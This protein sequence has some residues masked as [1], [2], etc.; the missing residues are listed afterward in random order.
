MAE[1]M[2]V[3]VFLGSSSGRQER[4]ARDAGA[5]GTWLAR[6]GY[7]LVYGGSDSGTMG[8]LAKAALAAGGEV[9]GIMPRVLVERGKKFAGLGQFILTDNMDD[10]KH[11]LMQKGDVIVGLPGGAGTLEEISE[12]MA[13]RL[14]GLICCPVLI[15]SPDGFYEPL[16]QQYAAMA[17]QG[18]VREEAMAPITFCPTLEAVEEKI[19][20]RAQEL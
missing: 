3:T 1:K 8:V 19:T 6:Q 13:N 20:A 11:L 10:R 5:L 9:T 4:Y 17:A 7:H 18:F 12:A 15:Y 2:K 14:L 16:R